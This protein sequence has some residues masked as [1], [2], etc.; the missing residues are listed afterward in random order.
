LEG[1][2]DKASGDARVA[3]QTLRSASHLADCEMT[4]FIEE[5][6]V[7]EGFAKAQYIRREYRL[8]KL[9]VHHRM[10]YELVSEKKRISFNDLTGEYLKRCESKALAPVSKRSL[11]RYIETLQFMRLVRGQKMR[12]F[13]SSSVLELVE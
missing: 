2:A 5:R 6:H 1:I 7:E 8:R 3:I 13:G 9:S 11:Y 12:S 10:V 4:G